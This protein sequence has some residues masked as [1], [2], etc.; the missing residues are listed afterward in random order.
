MKRL[1][2][3]VAAV[4]A[5]LPAAAWSATDLFFSEYIEGSSNNKALE[6]FN[7]TGATIDLGGY[8][9]Q[10]YFNGNANPGLTIPLVGNVA[11]GEVHV[12]AQSNAGPEILAEAD[13]T[14]GAGWFNGD[15]AVVLLFGGAVIDAIGQVGF[16]PG[17]QWGSGDASTQNNTLRRAASVDGGDTDPNDP[18]EPA[19]EWDGFPQDTFDD[20]GRAGDG[21]PPGGDVLINEVD[22]DTPD[23][24]MLEFV[25]LFD[26]GAGNTSLDGLVLVFFNGNGDASYRTLD[27]SGRQTDSN[28]YFVAGN[29]AVASV[30][31]V[32]PNDGLQNG[33]DAVALYRAA[34]ADFPNGTPVTTAGLVDALVYDTNDADDSDLLVLLNPGQAQVNEAGAGN[35]TSHSNQRCENGSGG[36]RNT[37]TYIQELAT[38]GAPNRCSP[39]VIGQC[40]DPAT[41]IHAIQGAGA[42]SPLV[43]SSQIIEG[44]VVGDFQG[45]DALEGFFVQ[46]EQADQDG[47][48]QTSEGIFVFDGSGA[49]AVNVGDIVRVGGSVREFF[50]MTRLDNLSGVTVCGSGASFEAAVVALPQTV[51][52]E[53]ERFEGMAVTTSQ[54]LVISE[55]FN[56]GSFGSVLLSA[57][58]R[59]LQPTQVATPGADAL[60][61]LAANNLNRLFLDDGSTAGNPATIPYPAPRLTADNTLRVGDSVAPLTGVLNFSFGE[62]RLQPTETPV[63]I[64]TNPRTAAPELVGQGDVRVASL[65]VLNYFNGD[66]QGGGFPT[67]RGADS[68]LEFERQ[69]AKTISAILAL[70]ADI[71]GLVEIE[72][73]GY[74]SDSAIQDLVNGLNAAG[75]DYA[76]VDPGVN[77][78]GTD[79]IAVGF[80][81][82]PQVVELVNAAAI[83]DASV[84]PDFID[85][86][87]R[88]VLAQTFRSFASQGVFTVAVTHLKSKGTPC[89][90]IGDPDIGDG[91]GNCNLTRTSAAGALARWVATDPTNSNDSDFLIIGDINAY[92][93]EDPIQALAA[94]GY[95]DLVAQ[96]VG[97]AA[98]SFVFRG[99]SGYLD[100][101]LANPAMGGQVVDLTEWLI[102]ADEPRALD[103]NLEDKSPLQAVDLYSAGPY[104]ASDHDPIVL[105]L[106]LSH[107]AGDIN[108][109]G[110]LSIRDLRI[111]VSRLHKAADGDNDPS[112]V[113]RDGVI[114]RK[115]LRRWLR[116]YIKS[117]KRRWWYPYH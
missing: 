74:G 87:N 84:D 62:Y 67:S 7:D 45:E 66:G 26:G 107:R 77:V 17:S 21:P 104:R 19:L 48:P 76:L 60:A 90:N 8:E 116:L 88:P 22:A 83:L 36:P 69:R 92:A 42:V 68:L 38:P 73:D 102:N 97:P 71:I 6:I 95:A 15:D 31:L 65:N 24:D 2:S 51:P 11:D 108:G 91:Q 115:D 32:F 96:F 27:L 81:Y 114:D 35:V 110:R 78:I 30:D 41:A 13:Q 82:R 103:Y 10:M 72:N 117:K 105:L 53:L 23:R 9:I 12:V 61:V 94:A 54:T 59:L 14:N 63:F 43:G 64:P 86:R 52:G 37:D 85:T 79:Q 25:E 1:L 49:V 20:L 55:N 57:D 58:S 33:A 70:D 34:A 44:V 100:Y 29:S 80:I 28:G 106:D 111:L 18:F 89:D 99:Q 98:H 109:D 16:D 5:V 47:D 40:G 39:V 3:S 75:A 4:V 56:L 101:A 50:G 113:N 46:E 112:D 93:K